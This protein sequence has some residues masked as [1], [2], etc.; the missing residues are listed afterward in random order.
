MKTKDAFVS[1][2]DRKKLM[3]ETE[4]M[5][6]IKHL[7]EEE[8]E[9]RMKVI[10]TINENKGKKVHISPQSPVKNT[11]IPSETV[12]KMFR[13]VSIHLH[14]DKTQDP[15]KHNDFLIARE[16]KE[17]GD[18]WVLYDVSYRNGIDKRMTKEDYDTLRKDLQTL[19]MD[20]DRLTVHP[21]LQKSVDAIIKKHPL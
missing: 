21:S 13:R 3:L 18:L 15:E 7:L 14:P 5:R 2:F 10:I 12:C 1:I 4:Y 9:G 8:V 16:A 6:K 20:V 19:R 11:H 17:K